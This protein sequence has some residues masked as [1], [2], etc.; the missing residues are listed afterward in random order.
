[1][2]GNH[3]GTASHVLLWLLRHPFK[4]IPTSYKIL[5]NLVVGSRWQAQIAMFHV[6]RSGSKVLADL[7]AQ[8]TGFIWDGEIYYQLFRRRVHYDPAR[9]MRLSRSRKR[10]RYYGFEVQRVHLETSEIDL[11]LLVQQYERLHITHYV[12]VERKNYLRVCVSTLVG[13]QTKRWHL[14]VA[15]DCELTR[16]TIEPRNP[17]GS[18]KDLVTLLHEYADYFKTLKQLLASKRVHHIIYED[19]IDPDPRVAYRSLCQFF[20]IDTE[21]VEVRFKK[22]NPTL[23]KDIIVN[24]DEICEVLRGTPFENMVFG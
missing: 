2:K 23:L 10:G 12:I 6:G 18:G 7:L 22:T 9:I 11:A 5:S 14:S 8:H 19:Q 20:E 1:M 3:Y 15:D 24:F 13:L 21:Q 16:I 4:I 17:F